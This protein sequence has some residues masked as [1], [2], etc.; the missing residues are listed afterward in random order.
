MARIFRDY[1]DISLGE[2][3]LCGKIDFEKIF[4][5]KGAVHV[6]IGSGRG[7]F[8]VNEATSFGELNFLG[9][10]WARRYYRY[11]VDR[12]GRWGLTN[13]R[14][15]RT[16]AAGFIA[17]YVGDGTVACYHIYFPDP[18]PKKRHHKRRFFND[19]NL[20]Q[21]LRSLSAGGII[22]LATDHADYF[23]QME[24][25][26]GRRGDELERVDFMATAGVSAGEWVGTNFEKKYRK[27]ERA[28]YTLAVKK[29]K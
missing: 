25:V 26:V 14:V 16:E 27:E 17:E 10:E 22:K 21:L 18:W 29:I 15:I 1:A 4:G 11:T 3:E 7:T 24:A 13:V 5:R 8:L 20:G 9:I 6:E 19:E 28:I 2:E 23:E 12:L